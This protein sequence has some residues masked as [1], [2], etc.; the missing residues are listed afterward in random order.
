MAAR[1][2]QLAVGRPKLVSY[3]GK[4]VSTAIFKHPVAGRAAVT[5]TNIDGDRQADLTV[6][7]GRDKAVYVYPAKHYATWAE[8][9][10]VES[11]EPAQFGENL[12]VSGV[13]ETT[14]TIG[15]RYRFGSSMAVVAQPRL[16][17]FKLGIRMNDHRFPQRFLASGRL[18]FYLRVEQEGDVGAGDAF[19]LFEQPGHDI[20]VHG[21]WQI[22][23][24]GGTP[25]EARQAIEL[26]PHLDDGWIRRLRKLAG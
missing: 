8:E 15:S 7:G 6:H 17:C 10:G 21:L 16:P 26:L 25:D 20:T 14:V 24:G 1:I 9:L 5:L 18:G 23:F 19:E 11:L 3:D 12:T 22:V 4:E 2:E 13:D